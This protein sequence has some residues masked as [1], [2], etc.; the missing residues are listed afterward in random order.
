MRPHR[1]PAGFTLVEL[2]V[3]L[4]IMAVLALMSWRGIDSMLRT[5]AQ[6]RAHT[7]ALLLVQTALAQ[8]RTDLD[9]LL[10]PDQVQGVLRSPLDWNGQVLRIARRSR[11]APGVIVAAWSR[12]DGPAGG[13]WLRWQSPLLQTRGELLSAWEQAALW[14]QNPGDAQKQHE[15][16]ITALAD[17]QLF[18]HRDAAWSHP[19]SSD[20]GAPSPG[21]PAAAPPLPDGVRLVLMLPP[22]TSLPGTLTLDWI[23]PT[24]GGHKS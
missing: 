4:S 3:A 16:A 20:A 13:I 10:A 18:Y 1:R 24:L 12:R 19:L 6:T 23:R 2:L 14:A 15:T 11:M 5:Q 17:W 7:D 9:A 21:Q 22:G 8:W